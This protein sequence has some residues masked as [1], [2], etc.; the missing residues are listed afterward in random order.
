MFSGGSGNQPIS[1]SEEAECER[2]CVIESLLTLFISGKPVILTQKKIKGTF[3]KFPL[4]NSSV[5]GVMDTRGSDRCIP[6]VP[7]LKRYKRR[8]VCIFNF[9]RTALS[10]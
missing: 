8:D 2:T 9:S 6:L 10:N 4:Q 5:S 1:D 3:L 7:E